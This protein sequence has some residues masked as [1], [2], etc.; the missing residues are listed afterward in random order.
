[1]AT[2]LWSGSTSLSSGG[3]LWKGFTGFSE[4]GGL[5]PGSAPVA[6]SV[7]SSVQADGWQGVW[8]SGTPPTFDPDG[9]PVTQRFTRQGYDSGANAITFDEDLVILRR[10]REVWPNQL[11]DTAANVALQDYVL[12]TDLLDGSP[13]GSTEVAPKPIGNW[14]MRDR[15]MVGDTIDW[16]IIAFHYYARE[17]RQVACVRVRANDGTT[18]TPWQVVSAPVV[19]TYCE[20]ANAVEVYRGTLDI[21]TLDPG[22]VALPAVGWLEAEI[23][24]WVGGDASVCRSEDSA[25]PREF[26]RRYFSRNVSR[27]ANPPL[28]YVASTG[29]DA[30]GVWSLTAATAAATP[31]LTVT[32]AMT[33]MTVG[34]NAA[35][36]NSI[37]DGC[38]VRIVDTVS[39]GAGPSTARPQRAA[40]LVI[41]RAPGTARAS[42]I[43]TMSASFR[44]RVGATGLVAP[45]TEGSAVFYDMTVNRTGA[46]TFIGE[47]S[48]QLQC[49]FHNVTMTNTS[50][51]SIHTT[52]TH[53][54]FFGIA[55]PTSVPSLGQVALQKRML[56][57]I[58]ADLNNTGME[59][60]VNIG[61]AITRPNGLG[62]ADATKP[63][64]GYSNKWLNPSSSGGVGAFN[65][66]VAGVDLGGIAWFQNLIEATHTNAST[67]GFRIANDAPEGL[68]NIVHAVVGHN[69]NTGYKSVNRNNFF[70]DENL[71]PRFHKF[72][73]YVGD[74]SSQLNT[75][76][77]IFAGNILGYPN[78]IGQFAFTHGVGC[79]GTYSMFQTNSAVQWSE[80]QTYPGLN[81]SIGTDPDTPQAPYGDVFIDY[82]GTTGSGGTPIAG[83]GGGDYNLQP[84]SPARN[85]VANKARSFAIDGAAVATVDSAGAYA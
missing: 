1:M 39:L 6:A 12:S 52:N 19:S 40:S 77:D 26:S 36:T 51:G 4:G 45:L 56:R 72:I 69:T 42:A 41:T 18:Q 5:S 43:A 54:Y 44:G 10:V 64:I 29:N 8:A 14:V 25:V 50:T 47:A 55:F 2:G 3:G 21:S 24:P 61:C 38:E 76:G 23:M 20:D 17:G 63:F 16:E 27:A 11:T 15:Q 59:G 73:K 62:F 53:V 57:G 34:G 83:A 58:V 9:A 33:A 85:R 13:C 84:A 74:L 46:F 30:T 49:N 71:A 81:S 70:Y 78:R 7:L 48:N 32:G 66:G 80:F 37:C 22:T 75:K 68:G 35:V 31:F 28:A 79:R 67:A 82:E 65:A 60:W